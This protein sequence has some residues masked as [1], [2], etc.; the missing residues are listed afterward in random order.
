MAFHTWTQ[1]QGL[2]PIDSLWDVLKKTLHSGLTLPSS[3]QDL[4][5]K[6]LQLSP[7]VIFL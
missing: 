4:G 6:R 1:T 7:D 5:E 3:I 2:N